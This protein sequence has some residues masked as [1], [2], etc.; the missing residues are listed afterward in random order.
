MTTLDVYVEN[1]LHK[2]EIP[3]KVLQH[4]EDFFQKMDRDMDRGWKIGPSYIENPDDTMRA[5]V[6]ASRLL[7]ALDTENENLAELMAGYIIS[8]LPGVEAVN[9]NT[10]GEPL[11][12]EF[13]IK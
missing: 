10:T 12:T 3:P 4:G 11:E 8:K 6:A 2:I 1:T 9:I 7:T 13:I 5:Q